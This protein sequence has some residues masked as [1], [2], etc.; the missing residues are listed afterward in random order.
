[1]NE[2]NLECHKVVCIFLSESKFWLYE[3]GSY[4]IRVV[5]WNDN[6]GPYVMI[7]EYNL[8]TFPFNEWRKNGMNTTFNFQRLILVWKCDILIILQG[9][10][11]KSAHDSYSHPSNL[12]ETL[13]YEV[14]K[15][16]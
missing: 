11:F 12:T 3:I 4:I 7:F 9:F 10:F 15:D 6:L 1:M 2:I 16:D 5:F 8:I 14:Y 13:A